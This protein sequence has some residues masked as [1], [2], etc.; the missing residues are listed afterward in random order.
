MGTSYRDLVAW[1]VALQFVKAIYEQTATFPKDE[2]FGLIS[3][4]RR[5]AVS[6]ASNIAEGQGR[7]TEG[8]FRHFLGQ[9]RGS[10]LEVETQ[11]YIAQELGFLSEDQL[12]TL[13]KLSHRIGLLLNGLLNSDLSHGPKSRAVVQGQ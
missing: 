13:L 7:L 3:Q 4:L 9:A 8:E 12:N 1:Q 11:L 2:R 10:L 5:A 6:V